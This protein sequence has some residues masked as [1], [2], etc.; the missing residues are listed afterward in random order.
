VALEVNTEN[1]Y[2]TEIGAINSKHGSDESEQD[3]DES[4]DQARMI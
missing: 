1:N 2:I 4:Q 3:S